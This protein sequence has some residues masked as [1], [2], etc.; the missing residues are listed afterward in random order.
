MRDSTAPTNHLPFFG[1]M[2]LGST[3]GKRERIGMFISKYCLVPPA[4]NY[5]D[6]LPLSCGTGAL[7]HRTPWMYSLQSARKP[8]C[9]RGH[10]DFEFMLLTWPLPGDGWRRCYLYRRKGFT[11][12]ISIDCTTLVVGVG[13]LV[14][15]CR[16]D[17]PVEYDS[18]RPPSRPH[19]QRRQR[20]I[21]S[22]VTQIL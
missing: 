9:A 17:N 10:A 12:Q 22:S 14:S 20:L 4:G 18:P 11:V 7:L 6:S 19:R 3:G 16:A 2:L 1:F 21:A 13:V 8:P 15:A 5:K